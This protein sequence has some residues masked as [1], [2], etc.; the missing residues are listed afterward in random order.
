MNEK[1]FHIYAKNKVLFHNIS[2]EEFPTMWDT[3]TGMVGLMKTDY[4]IEDLSYE[5]VTVTPQYEE[6]S[7]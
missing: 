5:E 3:I 1:V 7:Y 4:N 6:V 2:E